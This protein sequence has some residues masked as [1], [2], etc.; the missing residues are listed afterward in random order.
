MIRELWFQSDR[1]IHWL[2]QNIKSATRIALAYAHVDRSDAAYTGADER[3]LCFASF[4]V[5]SLLAPRGERRTKNKGSR[6]PR[7]RLGLND[8]P[9]A[10]GGIPDVAHTGPTFWNAFRFDFRVTGTPLARYLC[11][12]PLLNVTSGNRSDDALSRSLFWPRKYL[13]KN[14]SV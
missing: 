3:V 10:V 11:P 4:T 2:L 7:R 14:A 5:L 12:R 8:P 1:S 9:T 13:S 6:G